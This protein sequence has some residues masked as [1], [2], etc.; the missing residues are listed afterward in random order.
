MGTSDLTKQDIEIA[1]MVLR[2]TAQSENVLYAKA[3]KNILDNPK[4]LAEFAIVRKQRKQRKLKKA[5]ELGK[6]SKINTFFS[7]IRFKF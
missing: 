4:L 7:F 3:A 1:R 5:T 6:R 2:K